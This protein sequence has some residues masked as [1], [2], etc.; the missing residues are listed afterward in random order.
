MPVTV[1]VALTVATPAVLLLHT[2]PAAASA[3][4]VAVPVHTVVV[5]VIVP[6]V[7]VADTVTV[8]V[9]VAVPQLLVTV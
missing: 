1:P 9:A 8:V 4:V 6:A 3:N 5:P 2:P 7:G